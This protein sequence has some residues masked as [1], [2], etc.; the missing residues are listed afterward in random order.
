MLKRKKK[1]KRKCDECFQ[2]LSC[3]PALYQENVPVGGAV[4]TLALE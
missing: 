3:T 1:K 2:L 4:S